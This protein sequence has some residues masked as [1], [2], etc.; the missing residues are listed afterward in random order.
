MAYVWR[1]TEDITREPAAPYVFRQP[2]PEQRK[3]PNKK[4]FQLELCGT[5]AGYQQH[6]RYGTRKCAACLEAQA[7]YSAGYRV[8]KAAMSKIKSAQ[9]TTKM[10][11]AGPNKAAPE[12]ATNTKPGP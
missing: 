7:K 3:I 12:C 10:D 11:S 4:D 8:R 2:G 5:T 9:I 6:R 1:R